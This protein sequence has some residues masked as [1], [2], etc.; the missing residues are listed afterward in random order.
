MPKI[1]L[2]TGLRTFYRRD[3]SGF[4][5]V[6]I[7]G[8][9]L[10]HKCWNHQINSYTNKYECIRM[11]NRGT[12]LTSGGTDTISVPLMANDT[13]LLLDKLGIKRAHVSGLSLGSCVAQELAI[14]RPD[15]VKT[16]QLHGTWGRAYGYAKRK[17]NAQIKLLEEL[18]IRDFYEINSLWFYT[19]EFMANNRGKVLA[20]IEAI[21]RSKPNVKDLIGLYSAN[22]HHDTLSRLNQINVPTLITVG[23]FDVAVPPMYA[24]EVSENIPGSELVEFV[25]GGHLHNIENPKE[26]NEVT[27]DFLSRHS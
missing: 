5:L 24:K 6:L 25:G 20:Y 17:F 13:A 7:M 18:N 8:T 27:L 14:R 11:D 12:G 9:G 16:L 23:T 10:D 4:P 3:G 21:V 1:D 22:L 19:P 2:E 26:F 15:L